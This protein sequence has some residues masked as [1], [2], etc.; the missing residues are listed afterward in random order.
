MK[1]KD[2]TCLIAT[3]HEKE[4]AIRPS[5]ES[6]LGFKIALG[7]LN[8]DHFG[9]FTGEIERSL[10]PKDCAKIKCLSALSLHKEKIGIAN[11]GSFGPHP[12]IPFISADYEIFFFTDLELG[13]ELCLSKLFTETNFGGSSFSEFDP[14]LEFAKKS[15]FPSHGLIIRPNICEDK[16]ICFKGIQSTKDLYNAFQK[17]LFISQDKQVWVQTD[18]RAHKNPTRMRQLKKFAEEIA[19][20]LL[21]TCPV[22]SIPGW[23]PIDKVPGL[24]CADCKSETMLIKEV[25][26]GCCLCTHK[27]FISVNQNLAEAQYCFFCNP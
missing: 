15:L 3:M 2:K 22:C 25:I 16:A 18:M 27:E 13:Y 26:F 17:S 24:L 4:K 8:T 6:L 7:Q 20:R 5:F 1:Y 9:T 21:T 11:E 14:I 23:G 10:P 19:K 12:T